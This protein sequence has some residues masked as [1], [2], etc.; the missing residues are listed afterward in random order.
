MALYINAITGICRPLV[1]GY[2]SGVFGAV[3]NAAH[4]MWWIESRR[5]DWENEPEKLLFPC[6]LSLSDYVLNNTLGKIVTSSILNI[7]KLDDVND[8]YS[9]RR[10]AY[11]MI[12]R[13]WRGEFTVKKNDYFDRLF[14]TLCKIIN[15]IK[16]SFCFFMTCVDA[17][18]AL[19]FNDQTKVEALSNLIKNTVR[20]GNLLFHQEQA[21][22]LKIKLRFNVELIKSCCRVDHDT[23]LQYIENIY[24]GLLEIQKNRVILGAKVFV[25]GA[26]SVLYGR[27][28]AKKPGEN[29]VE[30]GTGF[31]K[32]AGSAFGHIKD[33]VV[34][35]FTGSNKKEKPMPKPL[36]RNSASFLSSF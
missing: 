16:E 24:N 3:L 31:V 35:A 18:K 33:C 4:S 27:N 23:A 25:L 10:E 34:N 28:P 12:G 2:H 26:N 5:Q 7:V 36:F 20:V 13:A 19:E 21:L 32:K 29:G 30:K 15:Y 17:A 1:Q 14:L 8:S 6:Q 11:N 22:H 9:K